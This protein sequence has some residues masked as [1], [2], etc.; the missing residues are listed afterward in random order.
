MFQIITIKPINS[1][2]PDGESCYDIHVRVNGDS[3]VFS[4]EVRPG[5]HGAQL[6]WSDEFQDLMM[7]HGADFAAVNGLLFQVHSGDA[8]AFPVVAGHAA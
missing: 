1:S 3:L 5:P 8:V 6:D 4:A 7:S 2:G